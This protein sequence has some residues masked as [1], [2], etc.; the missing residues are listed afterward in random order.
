MRVLFDS[1]STKRS[2]KPVRDLSHARNIIAIDGANFAARALH[3]FANSSR[4]QT[5]S[6]KQSGHIYGVFRM[7]HAAWSRFSKSGLTAVVVCL[8][9]YPSYRFLTTKTYKAHR[10]D[11]VDPE[12]A[13][14]AGEYIRGEQILAL[15]VLP[16]H[17]ALMPAAEADDVVG[18]LAHNIRRDQRL[19]VLSTDRDL[20]QLIAPNVE[21]VLR[22]YK[23]VTSAVCKAKMGVEP[24]QIPLVKSLYGDATDGI[25]KVPRIGKRFGAHWD[26]SWEVPQDI[27][28]A[29]LMW[30]DDHPLAKYSNIILDHREQ[31]N[32][33]YQT[34]TIQSQLPYIVEHF[35]GDREAFDDLVKKYEMRSLRMFESWFE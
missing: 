6:G 31:I 7:L 21:V 26:E 30:D 35:P 28:N 20:W 33:S 9:G 8:E 13:L 4:L 14:N 11:R 5:S 1:K 29:A 16:I 10:R 17:F 24:R 2:Q 32:R 15:S 34:A 18:A 12:T 3:V 23:P 27:F 22:D 25:P 19:I